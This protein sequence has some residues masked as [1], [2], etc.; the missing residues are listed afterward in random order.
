MVLDLQSLF[1]LH[2]YNCTHWLRPRSSPPPP[3]FV[4]IY[5][6]TIGQTR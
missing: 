1:G 6:G 3:A 4:R 5:K 2:V